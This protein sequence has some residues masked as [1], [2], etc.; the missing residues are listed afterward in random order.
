MALEDETKYFDSNRAQWIKD[1][2]EGEWAVIHDRQLLGFYRSLEEGYGAGVAQF[3]AGNF[4]LKQVS[5]ED[6]VETIQ[7]AYWGASDRQEAI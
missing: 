1:G 6:Q 2:H 5:P 3:G 7:R 4:L